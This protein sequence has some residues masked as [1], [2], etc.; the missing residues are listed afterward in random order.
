[1]KRNKSGNITESFE[2]EIDS[3]FG[4]FIVEYTVLAYKQAPDRRCVDSDADYLGYTEINSVSIDSLLK[5]NEE[6]EDYK[7]ILLESLSIETGN[8]ILQKVHDDAVV[9]INEGI[10]G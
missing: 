7:E 2:L 6:T 8:E 5:Y 10:G 1:M 3:L 4:S 9:K